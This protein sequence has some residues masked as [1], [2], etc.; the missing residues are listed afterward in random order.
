MSSN[1]L[2]KKLSGGKAGHDTDTS[3]YVKVN[4]GEGKNAKVDFT[5]VDGDHHLAR[6]IYK[7]EHGRYPQTAAEYDE[8]LRLKQLRDFTNVSTRPSDTHESY[9]NPDAYVGSGKGDVNK[10]LHPEKYGTPEKGTG[11]FNEQTA[12]NKQGKPLK[13]HHEQSAEA[14]KLREQLKTDTNLSAAEKTEIGKKIQHLESQSA[15][16]HYESVRTTAKEYNVISNINDVNMKNGLKDGLSKEAR[17]IG[18][19]ANKVAR[20]EMSAGQYQKL[21]TEAYGSEE[22]ALKIVAKGFRTTNL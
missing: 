21:V 4:T 22:N 12:I 9:R 3:P 8:A 1:D 7:A 20:G 15:S 5:Q 17:Q 19:W 16:N 11:V 13:L 2:A 18:E 14:Q 6:A 10:V